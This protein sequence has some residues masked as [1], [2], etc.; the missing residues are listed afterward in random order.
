MAVDLEAI[1][2]RG[3]CEPSSLRLALPLIEQ[4]YSPPFLARYRRDELSGLDESN[5]WH[6]ANAV[7]DEK[8]RT[9]FKNGL[10]EKWNATPLADPAIGNAIR[11]CNSQTILD[12]LAR[13]VRQE[14]GESIGP[15]TQLAVRVLNPLKADGSDLSSVASSIEGID[16]DAAIAGLD[17][18][19]AKR[20][21]GD[22]R[23]ISAAIRWLAKNAKVSIVSI[24]DPH[25]GATAEGDSTDLNSSEPE[26]STLDTDP[27]KDQT[28]PE[29][30]SEKT[31]GFETLVESQQPASAESPD[32]QPQTEVN[33]NATSVSE[34]SESL[35]P[36]VQPATEA[37]PQN[38]ASATAEGSKESGDPVD[39]S[40]SADH[41]TPEVTVETTAA[42]AEK[43]DSVAS[44]SGAPSGGKEKKG[45]NEAPAQPK[46]PKKV[47][48]RQRR[49]K[50]LVSVLKPLEGKRLAA[51]KL[52]SF[53]IV[54]LGR[55][56]RSQVAQ[57]TF[58]YDANK[59][60]TELK[61]VA[62]GFNRSLESKIVEIVVNNESVIR[63]AAEVA[64]WDELHER[65]STR[66]VSI[67]SD[68]LRR[69]INRGSVDAKVVMS[70]DA[71]GPR[72]AATTIVSVDGRVL[73]CDDLP[74]QL[75]AAQRTQTVSKM[76]ELIHAHNVDLIVISNGPARRACI[77]ALGDLIAQSPS[78][79]VRWTLADR[80]GA[81]AYA[82]SGI[83]D[84]EM[85]STSRRFRAAAW[86]A[87][88]ILQPALAFSKVDPLKLRL[89]SFQKELSDEALRESLD[90]VMTS[91][92]SRGGV[93]VN[94]A[95]TSALA[96]LPG[97]A[98]STVDVIDQQ[99]REALIQSRD[100]LAELDSWDSVASSRQSLPFLRVFGSEEVLDG[101][102][103]HPDDY[104]LA[105]KL[106]KSLSLELPPASPPGYVPPQFAS[107]GSETKS[108]P[109]LQ[110]SVERPTG[111]VVEDVAE[112]VSAASNPDFGGDVSQPTEEPASDTAD[113]QVAETATETEDVSA[114][115]D[116]AAEASSENEDA[117]ESNES[118]PEESTEAS[119]ETSPEAADGDAS[120]EN[121]GED[122]SGN[123]TSDVKAEEAAAQEPV[124]QPRPDKA[125]I[126][127]CI[128]EWQVGANRVNQLV[129]WLCDPFGD[130][131]ASGEPPAVLTKIPSLAALNAGDQAV[132]VVVGVMP[133]GVFVELAP[134]CSGL[135]HVSK[136]T[137][138][139]VEDLHEAI[140]VGD[141][142]TAW[143][144]SVDPKKKRVALSAIS[145]QREAELREA[146]ENRPQ[147]GRGGGRSG[148]GKPRGNERGGRDSG[149]RDSGGRGKPQRGPSAKGSGKGGQKSDRGSK[150]SRDSGGRGDSRRGRGGKRERKPESYNVVGKKVETPISDA[151][152]KGE[153]PLRSFGDL[154]QYYGNQSTDKPADEAPTE[155]ASKPVESGDNVT[156]SE[157]M[158]EQSPSV[159]PN[160]EA[161]RAPSDESAG[162]DSSGGKPENTGK[163]PAATPDPTPSTAS[164]DA[165]T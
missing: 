93:D 133:F 112:K 160:G 127:K 42:D 92:A 14:S 6:L 111:V 50:W 153:E 122:A 152:Q 71:V 36:V 126:D 131:D 159:E 85:K 61:K 55:A 56:L 63:E 149:G 16:A 38:V 47:S 91:G 52:S 99:R 76:G 77:V 74:C 151:M 54:M 100:A 105:K 3:R 11:K 109:G 21:T 134:D 70:I 115:S 101:T 135:I 37:A 30:A 148:G 146:R 33:T 87:F 143:V 82:G 29:G 58:D 163:E 27:S 43:V 45:K 94:S 98:Q 69:Q 72:T 116:T 35:D 1:A 39:P 81:D 13:R 114:S 59:L 123:D 15:A 147:T 66:L 165:S 26:P 24:S 64:W 65:A 137:D 161:S 8:K 75:S 53:Q 119:S 95:S 106:A 136:V 144:T 10:L 107:E 121:A 120:A 83:A 89:S 51:N 31:P 17:E 44:P 2:R 102:L 78:G 117:A 40:T 125:K 32:P 88:S 139:Y 113:E 7:Q 48:P 156:S 25:T 46:K 12:R 110:E 104:A 108:E 138:N 154:L 19:I 97:M 150:R 129:S 41:V 73:H 5:L 118:T 96:R 132:G 130:S 62:G 86:L 34:Q 23:L 140:Q 4:G 18:A 80:S 164:T 60:V 145:P 103:I 90:N 158:T 22:P 68:H 142:V 49:R 84:Q 67:A 124:R 162:N 57:C 79:S 28:L 155:K 20:L 9:A 141:V 128:K 157:D